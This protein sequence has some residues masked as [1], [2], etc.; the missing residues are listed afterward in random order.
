M[1]ATVLSASQ[2]IANAVK[3]GRFAIKGSEARLLRY[4]AAG[5]GGGSG[6]IVDGDLDRFAEYF[7]LAASGVSGALTEAAA[8]GA[9]GFVLKGDYQLAWSKRFF[10]NAA[11]GASGFVVEKTK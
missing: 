6:F 10:E 9:S 4:F 8:N 5:A 7:L 1:K 2:V 11:T 3:E